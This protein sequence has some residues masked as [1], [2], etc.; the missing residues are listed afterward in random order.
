MLHFAAYQGNLTVSKLLVDLG[1]N[2]NLK[3]RGGGLAV[4]SACSRNHVDVAE[5]FVDINGLEVEDDSGDTPLIRA[6]TSGS[7]KT[8]DMLVRRCAAVLVGSP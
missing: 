2:V 5:F 4:H 3:D 6:A 1:A 7:M 8:F